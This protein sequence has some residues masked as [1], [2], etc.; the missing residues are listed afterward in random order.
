MSLLF[1]SPL[2]YAEDDVIVFGGQYEDKTEKESTENKTEQ[3]TQIE[4][5]I[6]PITENVPETETTSNESETNQN[7][8]QDQNPIEN[9]P[10][11]KPIKIEPPPTAQVEEKIEQPKNEIEIENLNVE[12][13]VEPEPVE[14]NK[15]PTNINPPSHEIKIPADANQKNDYEVGSIYEDADDF[16][17]PVSKNTYEID[18]KKR[19]ETNQN[20]NSNNGR[21]FKKAE[22]YDN[23]NR[24][25][26]SRE[27]ARFVKLFSDET[28]DY[29]LDRQAVRWINMPYSTSEYMADVWIRMLERFPNYSDMDSDLYN[30]VSGMNT[31]IN[32]AA[33]KGVIYDEIDLKVLHTKKY[34][35][36]HYYIRPK[37]KQIQFLCELEVI[38]RPQNA[39]SERAYDY[40]N[41][42]HLIP[43]SIETSIYYSVLSDIG[44]SR[45]SKRGHMTF[46]DHLDEYF[47]IALN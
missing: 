42:E 39:I 17:K 28:Y 32:E 43:G 45:A 41:W 13:P 1:S 21:Y 47:R 25:N 10:E 36:E 30:Y 33:K 27:R 23:P 14:E 22:G 40:R 46:A 7:E 16:D 31:E 34:F 15:K 29:Y 4:E 3:P 35:L 19:R 9:I 18:N 24:G 8:R 38:G 6:P 11:E 2:T 5:K 20:S 37:T 44:Q 12:T 26:E